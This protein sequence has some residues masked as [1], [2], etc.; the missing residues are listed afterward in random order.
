MNTKLTRKM[1][2]E[3]AEEFKRLALLSKPVLDGLLI[4]IKDEKDVLIDSMSTLDINLETSYQVSNILGK[5][6]SLNDLE[7]IILSIFK[8]KNNGK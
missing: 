2:K 1:T 3:Q 8:E 7:N 5:I 4:Y 6:H